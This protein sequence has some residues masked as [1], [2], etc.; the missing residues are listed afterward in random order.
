MRIF[1]TAAAILFLL[2][3]ASVA[4]AQ[5]ATSPDPGTKAENS[6]Q[7][8]QAAQAQPKHKMHG[9]SARHK[10]PLHHPTAMHR[11]GKAHKASLRSKGAK[12]G[13]AEPSRK[14]KA[15]TKQSGASPTY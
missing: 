8:G 12:R 14:A 2:A 3:P 11:K 9:K 1:S 15:T 7:Q 4:L 13:K 5:T 10:K 6:M